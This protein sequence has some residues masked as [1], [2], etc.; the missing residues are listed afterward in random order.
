MK[1]SVVV[2]TRNRLSNLVNTL[3][4]LFDQTLDKSE[5]EVIV[6]DD[7][8]PDETISIV[9]NFRD[10]GNLKYIFSNL[11]KGHT[12]NASVIR[13]L[14]VYVS[15]KISKAIVFVDSD[16]ILPNTALQY[17]L[18][19]FE[20]NP[21]RVIIGS[22]DFYRQGNETIG[23][24]D[25]RNAKFG[26]VNREETFDTIHDGLACFGGNLLIPKD[27]FWSVG[28]FDEDVHIG[29]EDGSMGIKLWKKNTKFSY[30]DRLR[31]KHQW[32]ETPSDRF[33]NDMAKH[34]NYLNQKHFHMD[35]QEVDKSMDLITA[36]KET[37]ASWGF[38]DW[39]PP[40]SWTKNEISFGLKVNKEGV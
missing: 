10:R 34:V 23:V 1:L 6:V 21:N 24:P 9:R 14:G 18:E 15:D 22:Y 19:D 35:T 13:N 32:H 2:P 36:T 40:E 30:D 17:Y 7:N 11:P 33:P 37:Y 3:S 16:V 28:G 8:S 20:F 29:L 38:P 5:Y 39:V 25:V 26:S 31:G 12:W 4:S 27:I